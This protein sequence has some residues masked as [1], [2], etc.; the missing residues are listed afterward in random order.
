MNE[1][2]TAEHILFVQVD[3]RNS[4]ETQLGTAEAELRVLAFERGDRGILVTAYSP[5]EFT[6]ELHPDV[7]FGV[8]YEK[9]MW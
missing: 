3:D 9:C 5:R 6:L 4:L 7:P 2:E 8:S 1:T